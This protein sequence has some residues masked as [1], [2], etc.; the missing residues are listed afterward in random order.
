MKNLLVL[1][2]LWS[3]SCFCVE[4]SGTVG[5][6]PND[7]TFVRLY[8]SKNAPK[9]VGKDVVVPIPEIL[10]YDLLMELLIKIRA[11]KNLGASLV[12]TSSIALSEIK[13]TGELSQYLDLEELIACAGADS[14]IENG[15]ERLV[16]VPAP[17][18]IRAKNIHSFI[19]SSNHPELLDELSQLLNKA[20]LDFNDL[21]NIS[22]KLLGR[23]IY[24]LSASVA[25]VN[26][27][28][29]RTLAEIRYLYQQGAFVHLVSPYLPYARSDK[30]E[31]EHGV[32]AQGRLVADLIECVGTQ[33]IT[34]V[35]AHAPQSLGFFKIAAH[36]ISGRKTIIE[37]L[38][39]QNV[40]HVIS[41]DAGFQK[42]ATKYQHELQS[43]SDKE[44]GLSVMNKE[45]S[46]DGKEKINGGTN[47]DKISGRNTV[48]IDDETQTGG[49]AEKVAQIISAHGAKSIFAVVT[50]L[51]GPAKAVL[52]SKVIQEMVVTNTLPI[53]AKSPL[54]R[55][56][57]IAK[58]IA[59][60]ISFED[61]NAHGT[62]IT[63]R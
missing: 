13:I 29:F 56:L 62:P 38:K 39:S 12:Q 32:I 22:S 49:T 3:I 35:R 2:F 54:L 63:I 14:V 48:I 30:P 5:K 47:L 43:I 11:A 53:T 27:H 50:H 15:E 20:P 1:A 17:K 57:S 42:D 31:Y 34:V 28:F 60:S 40:E 4:L 59:E 58:E 41:P 21:A 46:Y 19:G 55:V 33:A 25:P 44:I 52:N 37:F 7:N 18:R 24:W 9:I 8:D 36:E 6:F 26:D 51:A 16:T 45:R 61:R 10:N 23:K